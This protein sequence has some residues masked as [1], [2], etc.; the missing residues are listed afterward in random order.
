MD[1]TAR[2][3]GNVFGGVYV[4]V[5]LIGFALTGV[6]GFAASNGPELI[7]FQINPLHN[8]VHVLIGVALLAAAGAGEAVARQVTAVVGA[9][10][11]VVGVL[12]FVLVGSGS[13]NIL[14]LNGADNLLHLG[15]AAAA[16][17]TLVA[18]RRGAPVTTV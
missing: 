10:Y 1:V 6:D 11:G 17:L 13:L 5:G 9:V 15:T 14:A 7:I 2:L 3:F 16:A 12:G 18:A 4:A 8:V